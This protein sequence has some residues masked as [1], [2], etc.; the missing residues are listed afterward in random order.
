MTRRGR[1]WFCHDAGTPSARIDKGTRGEWAD[2]LAPLGSPVRR[3]WTN[4]AS[5]PLVYVVLGRRTGAQA[6]ETRARGC[7]NLQRKQR[8]GREPLHV[9][10]KEGAPAAEPTRASRVGKYPT[11]H[12]GTLEHLLKQ[13][14][15]SKRVDLGGSQLTG[16]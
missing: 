13:L 3:T 14:N 9:D 2:V 7:W 8:D 1:G 12:S 15:V 6:A 5:P 16:I 11:R 4:F 10:V